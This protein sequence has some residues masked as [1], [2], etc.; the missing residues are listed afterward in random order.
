MWD[1]LYDV[2]QGS[3][4][5]KYKKLSDL[6]QVW[7][8]HRIVQIDKSFAANWKFSIYIFIIIM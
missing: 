6:A 2:W 5:W 7:K 1:Q 3:N 4:H 8:N